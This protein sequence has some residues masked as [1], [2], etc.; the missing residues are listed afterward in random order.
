MSYVITCM[1]ISS[2]ILT[3]CTGRSAGVRYTTG[4][5]R[6]NDLP[7]ETTHDVGPVV[8]HVVP[9]GAAAVGP[10]TFVKVARRQVSGATIVPGSQ[11]TVDRVPIECHT[12]RGEQVTFVIWNS[13]NE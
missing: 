9:V 10:V 13:R 8:G 1:Y 2:H 4:S 6:V 11:R 5:A 7:L 12:Y 3:R